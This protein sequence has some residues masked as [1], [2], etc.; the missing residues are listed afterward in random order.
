MSLRQALTPD[1][2]RGRVAG[3][4]RLL[5]WGAQPLGAL[6]GG[7]LGTA[8]G[9]RAPFFVGAVAYA[10]MLVVTWAIT[11]NKSIETAR[12]AAPFA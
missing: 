12:A 4:A 1:E 7:I 11:S 3:S 10:V 6:L 2:L 5:A 9:V 8:Y